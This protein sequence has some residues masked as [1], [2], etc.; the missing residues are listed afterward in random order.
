ML[1]TL[2]MVTKNNHML[3]FTKKTFQL[4]SNS[5]SLVI[6]KNTEDLQKSLSSCLS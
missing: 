3:K 6:G 1:S 2:N 4:Y 5:Y